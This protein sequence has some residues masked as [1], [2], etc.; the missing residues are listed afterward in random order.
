SGEVPITVRI[1]GRDYVRNF[2]YAIS[3]KGPGGTTKD[4]RLEASTQFIRKLNSGA[5]NPSTPV[6][7]TATA[8][9]TTITTWQYSVNGGTFSTTPPVGVTRSGNVVS[10]NPGAVIAYALYTIR[11]SDGTISDTISVIRLEDGAPGDSAVT[12]ILSNES[13]TFAGSATAALAG[14]TNTAILAFKGTQQITPTSVIVN[15]SDL[16]TGM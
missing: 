3:F 6:T 10:I 7:V 15:T 2:S 1:D 8:V 12:L 14:S 13:H 5:W 4:I 9:N 11:A 16:P